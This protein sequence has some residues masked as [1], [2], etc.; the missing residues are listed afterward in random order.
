[1]I[2]GAPSERPVILPIRFLDGKVV[3]A[4]EPALHQ[5]PG[6][7]FPILVS[8][9]AKQLS[10]VISPFIGVSHGDPIAAEGPELLYQAVLEL[11]CPFLR[12]EFHDV[13]PSVDEFGAI[14]PTAVRCI[15]QRNL[16]GIAAVPAVFREANL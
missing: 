7:I 16:L 14:P 13:G 3:D 1:M 8:V 2:V 10:P 4:S 11:L 12:E 5:S 15:G 9:R 6:I